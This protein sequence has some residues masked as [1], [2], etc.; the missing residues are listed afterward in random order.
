[1]D[2]AMKILYFE[3]VLKGLLTWYDQIKG[4]SYDND[5]SILKTLKLLF[6]VSAAKA[7]T[8]SHSRLLEEVFDG[9]FAMPYGHVESEIYDYIRQQGGVLTYYIVDNKRTTRIPDAHVETLMGKLDNQAIVNEIDQSIDY[10]KKVNPSLILMSPFDL[11]NLSHA[12][13]SWQYY[14]EEAQKSGTKSIKIPSEAIK[15]ENKLFSLE[16]F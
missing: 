3:Y 12:W 13:Y 1:M 4:R 7:T 6:F 15:T 16:L 5:L 11:V 10:L 9:F 8:N 2:K 14:Y